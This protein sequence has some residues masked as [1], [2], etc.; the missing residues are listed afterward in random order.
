M[1]RIISVISLISL[2]IFSTSCGRSTKPSS[3][4]ALS[5]D[6]FNSQFLVT[7]G[8]NAKKFIYEQ[9]DQHGLTIF[10]A[11]DPRLYPNGGPLQPP[12]PADKAILS[13]FPDGTWRIRALVIDRPGYF[14][15]K[16]FPTGNFIISIAY[17][18]EGVAYN[19]RFDGLYA[20]VNRNTS[21]YG[22]NY[23]YYLRG[24]GNQVSP[25]AFDQAV[26]NFL[27]N[28]VLFISRR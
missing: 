3:S 21:G 8:E 23:L 6:A 28:S 2:M 26:A 20:S 19:S 13:V 1:T 9:L 25:A 14:E 4:S 7:A 5:S 17:D 11:R 16:E 24:L 27:A 15:A 22:W 10:D 12:T 18:V